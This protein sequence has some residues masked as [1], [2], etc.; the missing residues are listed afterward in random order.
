[1]DGHLSDTH[2]REKK[3]KYRAHLSL[4]CEFPCNAHIESCASLFAV[5][6]MHSQGRILLTA[7]PA[8]HPWKLGRYLAQ[9]AEAYQQWEMV[10]DMLSMFVDALP[11]MDDEDN[12]S[13]PSGRAV[14]HACLFV[15]AVRRGCECLVRRTSCPSHQGRQRMLALPGLSDDL[16]IYIRIP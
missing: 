9:H 12:L 11:L 15:P 16:P 13:Q 2:E 7:F 3:R 4:M 8:V 6:S 14:H 10:L 1:M 5:A